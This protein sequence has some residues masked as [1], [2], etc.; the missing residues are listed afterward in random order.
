MALYEP[1]YKTIGRNDEWERIPVADVSGSFFNVLGVV[2]F[3]GAVFSATDEQ[4]RVDLAVL[5][6]AL[7]MTRFGADRQIIG[8]SLE[9]GGR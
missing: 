9:L 6:H 4:R 7:W 2:P 5:S 3:A 1:D 8:K